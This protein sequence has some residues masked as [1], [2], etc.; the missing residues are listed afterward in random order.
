MYTVLRTYNSF[1]VLSPNGAHV[2][3]GSFPFNPTRNGSEE[4]AKKEAEDRAKYFNS[5]R[6]NQAA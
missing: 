1:E 5:C 6:K 4:R 2:M 3:L